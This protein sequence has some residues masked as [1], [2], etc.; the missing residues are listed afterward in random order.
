ME[1]FKPMNVLILL[2]AVSVPDP[3]NAGWAGGPAELRPKAAETPKVVGPKA[4]DP[5]AKTPLSSR[6]R[7]ATDP[8]DRD[9]EG[10][11]SPAPPSGLRPRRVLPDAEGNYSYTTSKGVVIERRVDENGNVQIDFP[12]GDPA[13]FS[14]PTVY[15]R[16]KERLKA[17]SAL[18]PVTPAAPVAAPVATPVA[19]MPP[20]SSLGGPAQYAPAYAP[21]VPAPLPTW[22]PLASSP[23]Y[24]AYGTVGADGVWRYEPGSVR[25]MGGWAAQAN[26]S[27]AP[28]APAVSYAPPAYYSAPA[29]ACGPYG[30]NVSGGPVGGFGPRGGLLGFGVLGRR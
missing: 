14:E 7:F 29:S 12:G 20:A 18:A 6:F 17:V 4:V 28:V 13:K 24:E 8:Q 11:A 16:A 5:F 22:Q 25:P 27:M 15:E 1:R 3:D 21:A 23:G 9:G 30:C 19:P 2:V 26:V 10:D